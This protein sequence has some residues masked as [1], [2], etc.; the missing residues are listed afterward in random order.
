MNTISSGNGRRGL[1]PKAKQELDAWNTWR[2]E[3]PV[4]QPDLSGA[5]LREANLNGANLVGT[6]PSRR[7]LAVRPSFGQTSAGPI[8]GEPILVG[9]TSLMRYFA[10]RTSAR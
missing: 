7:I 1:S 8:S 4:E 9:L 6:S 3:N 2:E 5:D 10:K